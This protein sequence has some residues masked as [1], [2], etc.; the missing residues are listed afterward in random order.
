MKFLNEKCRLV[1]LGEEW[2]II[3]K[4]LYTV[5]YEGVDWIQLAQN[6]SYREPLFSVKV[7]KYIDNLSK[8]S[9][10]SNCL[11]DGSFYGDYLGLSVFYSR[12]LFRIP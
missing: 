11:Y 4:W 7:R 10:S 12:D 1:S 5:W 2:N 3:L 9:A 8:D 6:I